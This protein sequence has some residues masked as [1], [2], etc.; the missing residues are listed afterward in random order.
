MVSENTKKIAYQ[1]VHNIDTS[2]KQSTDTN[3]FIKMVQY[4]FKK[5]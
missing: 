1:P 3:G 4:M 5:H 2:H